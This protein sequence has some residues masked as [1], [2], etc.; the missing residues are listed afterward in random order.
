MTQHSSTPSNADIDL[1]DE[2]AK[3]VREIYR[4]SRLGFDREAEYIYKKFTEYGSCEPDLKCLD[5]GGGE[6][7][8][9]DLGGQAFDL[10]LREHLHHL[11]IARFIELI[12][13][14]AVKAKQSAAAIKRHQEHYQMKADVFDWLGSNMHNYKSMDATAEAIA[15]KVVPLAFRTVRKWVKEY[16]DMQFAGRV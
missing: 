3:A 1:G 2:L 10:E 5:K 9:H 16:K 15:G 13:N 12:L 8:I 6:V 4:E 14:N 11:T 7:E